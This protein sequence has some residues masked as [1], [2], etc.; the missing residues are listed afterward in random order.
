MRYLI[1][2]IVPVFRVEKYL[3]D[4]L[5]SLLVGQGDGYEVIA[6]NDC[7]PDG[8]ASI[9]HEYRQKYPNLNVIEFPQNRGVSAARV[10]GQL[11]SRG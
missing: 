11:T 10:L 6:V 2:I 3:R 5:D 4:C 9:L 1:S 7:S 8:S